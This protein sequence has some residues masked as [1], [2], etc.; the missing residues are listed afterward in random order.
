MSARWLASLAALALVGGPRVAT[1]QPAPP[2]PAPTPAPPDHDPDLDHDDA[3]ARP[4]PEK[5]PSDP[6]HPSFAPRLTRANSRDIV[7]EIPGERSSKNLALLAGI[8]TAA[9]ATGVFGLYYNLDGKK[10]ADKVNAGDFTG[11][12]WTPEAQANYDRAERDRTRAI[13]LY[14]AAGALAVATAVVLI[15]TEPASTTTTIHPHVASA[16]VPM[17]GGGAFATRAWRF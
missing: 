13:V 17:P 12:V 8:G 14:S 1:A 10:A 5:A 2:P 9:L 4:V 3:P 11:R 6:D 7:I 16:I 15:V